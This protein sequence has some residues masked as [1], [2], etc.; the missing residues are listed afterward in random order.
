MPIRR[1]DK[2]HN[3]SVSTLQSDGTNISGMGSRITATCRGPFPAIAEEGVAGHSNNNLTNQNDRTIL[4]SGNF[5]SVSAVDASSARSVIIEPGCAS[6][7]SAFSAK[8]VPW[9]VKSNISSMVEIQF[10]PF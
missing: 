3:T 10:V 8:P 9:Q 5:A 7:D 4:A 2:S 6:A 1:A